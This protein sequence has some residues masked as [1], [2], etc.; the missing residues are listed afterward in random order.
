MLMLFIAGARLISGNRCNSI[1][2]R[3]RDGKG[4]S[5]IL[6]LQVV[7]PPFALAM[8]ECDIERYSVLVLSLDDGALLAPHTDIW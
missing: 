4:S 6:E 5:A 8:L 7:P 3:H 1:H 2:D